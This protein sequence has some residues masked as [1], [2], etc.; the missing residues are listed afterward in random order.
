MH[1]SFKLGCFSKGLLIVRLQKNVSYRSVVLKDE[2]HGQ[3]QVAKE[4]LPVVDRY[5]VVVCSAVEAGPLEVS[6]AKVVV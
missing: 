6:L 2:R 4:V 1:R 5:C 3:S